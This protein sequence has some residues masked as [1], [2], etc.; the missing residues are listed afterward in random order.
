VGLAGGLR[1]RAQAAGR[2]LVATITAPSKAGLPTPMELWFRCFLWPRVVLPLV[3]RY[4]DQFEG[5]IRIWREKGLL[6]GPGGEG[7]AA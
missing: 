5:V 6:T 7:V 2:R 4:P 1:A 3:I